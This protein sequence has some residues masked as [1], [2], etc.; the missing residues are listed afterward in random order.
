MTKTKKF[1]MRK[2]PTFPKRKECAGWDHLEECTGQELIGHLKEIEDKWGV[3]PDDVNF[4]MDA[5][6]EGCVDV[7]FSYKRPM[8]DAEFKILEDRYWRARHK[9]D[10]WAKDHANE[11]DSHLVQAKINRM[12]AEAKARKLEVKKLERKALK[13]EEDLAIM[14]LKLHTMKEEQDD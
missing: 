9:Y 2:E 1:T 7:Y 11:I 3:A 4:T 8:T 12:A 10:T 5:D 14:K 6:W 13:A